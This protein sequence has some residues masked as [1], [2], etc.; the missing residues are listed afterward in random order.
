MIELKIGVFGKAL[1]VSGTVSKSE[2]ANT[3]PKIFK[4]NLKVLDVILGNRLIS[5]KCRW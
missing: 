2:I 1:L 4:A 5:Q 3:K